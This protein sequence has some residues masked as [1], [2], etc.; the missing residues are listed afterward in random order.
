MSE[1]IWRV[2]EP[3]G[4]THYLDENH[5]YLAG[6]LRD[7]GDVREAVVRAALDRKWP[8]AEVVAPGEM[9]RREESAEINHAIDRI[10][11]AMR[12]PQPAGID[13]PF[14]TEG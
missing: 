7:G 14:R 6:V 4:T 8:I 12:S 5:T 2:V 10:D 13:A 9:T 3:N 1:G 11:L